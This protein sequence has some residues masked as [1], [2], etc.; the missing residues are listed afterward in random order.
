MAKTK[1]QN[2]LL[3]KKT[4][5]INVC[6]AYFYFINDYSINLETSEVNEKTKKHKG[7]IEL[8]VSIS[9]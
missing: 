5:K 1:A 3:K 9:F 6:F 4:W 7:K 2:T 8:G